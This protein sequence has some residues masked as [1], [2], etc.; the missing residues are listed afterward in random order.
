M[1]TIFKCKNWRRYKAIRKPRCNNGKPCY[2]CREKYRTV[3]LVLRNPPPPKDD[4]S[5]Y[6][7]WWCTIYG[8]P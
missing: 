7:S 6:H 5:A 1:K 2:H 3:Q 8:G 4:Y